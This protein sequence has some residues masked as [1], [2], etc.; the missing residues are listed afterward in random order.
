MTAERRREIN[1]FAEVVRQATGMGIP[2]EPEEAVRVLGGSIAES[3]PDEAIAEALIE[4][5]GGDSF[6]IVTTVS[7]HKK[8]TRFSVAHEL[9]HLFLH[10]GYLIDQERWENVGEYSESVYTRLGHSE[11]EHEA[12]EFG[13]AFLMPEEEFRA[14][15]H[16][17]LTDGKYVLAPIAHRFGVSEPA[18]R[19]RGQ[20]LGLF[21]WE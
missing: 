16:A 2:A 21:A 11:D 14:A 7:E 8:R 10:M 4:K 15:A 5:I 18:A 13:A 17:N 6:R 9:G 12:N 3:S 19:T 20:W 1:R